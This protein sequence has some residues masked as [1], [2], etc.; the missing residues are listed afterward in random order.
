LCFRKELTL[1]FIFIMKQVHIYIKLIISLLLIVW[2]S[3]CELL[4]GRNRNKD[5]RGDTIVVKKDTQAKIVKID[6]FR[7]CDTLAAQNFERL[8]VCYEKVGDKITRRDT[9]ARIQLTEER[10]IDSLRRINEQRNADSLALL[11]SKKAQ[12]KESYKVVILMPFMSGVT[13]T[14]SSE[15]K[16]LRAIEFYE[17]FLMALDSLRRENINMSISVFDTQ[18][19]DSIVEQLLLREELRQA[20][21]IVGPMS[22]G[23]LRLVSNFAA[24]Y[25]IPLISPLN[26]RFVPEEDNPY[27]LQIN[28]S[29]AT[30]SENIFAYANKLPIR[31]PKNFIVVGTKD[32]SLIMEQ[33]Q[34]AYAIYKN[35]ANARAEMYIS[36]DNRFDANKVKDKYQR[37]ALNIVIAPTLKEPF[38]FGLLRSLSDDGGKAID[39]NQPRVMQ[40]SYIVFGL[41][42]WKYFEE[43]NFEYFEKLRLHLTSESFIDMK[44]LPTMRFRDAYVSEYGMPP[45]DFAYIGFDLTIYMG[46]MLKKHGT[47]FLAA[48]DKEPY[49]GRHTKF[50]IRPVYRTFKTLQPNGDLQEQ[51]AVS[52]YENSFI[53]ILK[54]EEFTLKKATE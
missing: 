39:P 18:D 29:Y 9:V 43:I 30:Q 32:D 27:F 31:R 45:R 34:M 51:S 8:V 26:P 48:L 4:K 52:R 6:T 41:S 33:F 38:V 10:R 7:A 47:G 21:V 54:F 2:M 11:D 24:A 25:H 23:E 20:D 14:G 50:D 19:N 3:S 13:R 49:T 44:N 46:R 35:D 1:Y 5:L 12:L 28:P 16:S 36:Q 40:E 17:G 22:S 37:N 15:A 42:Q 53:H